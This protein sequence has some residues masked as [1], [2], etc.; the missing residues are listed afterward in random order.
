LSLTLLSSH[1]ELGE[2]PATV[3]NEFRLRRLHF[4]G[5]ALLFMPQAW[6]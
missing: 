3:R 6:T 1:D 5:D 2:I 4:T